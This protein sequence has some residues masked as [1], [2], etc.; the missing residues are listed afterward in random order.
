[1]SQPSIALRTVAMRGCPKMSYTS[2]RVSE[3]AL[4]AKESYFLGMPKVR[5]VGGGVSAH[6]VQRSESVT[7]GALD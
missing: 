1:M 7:V 4:H 5:P 3:R 6:A 2:Q